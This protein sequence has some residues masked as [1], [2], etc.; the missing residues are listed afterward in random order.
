MYLKFS[1]FIDLHKFSINFIR[2][3]FSKKY[4]T[5]DNLIFWSQCNYK[6]EGSVNQTIVENKAIKLNVQSSSDI[7]E[8]IEGT[9]IV[10]F[11]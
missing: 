7:L 8:K 2:N 6:A 10:C 9:G 11:T 1:E 4:L 5:K 3:R